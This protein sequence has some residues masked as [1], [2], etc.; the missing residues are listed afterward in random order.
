M[1]AFKV[2]TPYDLISRHQL[3]GKYNASNFRAESG[4]SIFLRKVVVDSVT[5]RKA[6]IENLH[7]VTEFIIKYVITCFYPYI[8]IYIYIYIYSPAQ[9]EEKRCRKTC[10][11]ATFLIR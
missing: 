8:Y 11:A 4:G 1:L 5:T 6:N 9:N 10:H 7:L 2:V 3:F